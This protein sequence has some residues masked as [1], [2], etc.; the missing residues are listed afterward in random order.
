MLD[1]AAPGD[2]LAAEIKRIVV[3]ATRIDPDRIS[4]DSPFTEL[5]M[6]SID[7]ISIVFMLED[8]FGIT[9]SDE[10]ARAVTSIRQI[11]ERLGPLLMTRNGATSEA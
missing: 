11:V 6:D 1:S 7:A 5:G 10:D 8:E 9:I 3:K 2:S 4:T